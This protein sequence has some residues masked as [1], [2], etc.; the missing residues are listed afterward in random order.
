M[1]LLLVHH[2][3]NHL[4]SLLLLLLVTLC[5]VIKQGV[6]ITCYMCNSA[7][8][9]N[10]HS[11]TT[12]PE[13]NALFEQNCDH[14]PEALANRTNYTVCRKMNQKIF[15]N[16]GNTEDRI[17]RQCAT[18]TP[19]GCTWQTRPNTLHVEACHCETDLC[20]AA[21]GPGHSGTAWLGVVAPLLSCWLY[22][23]LALQTAGLF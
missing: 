12:M 5:A 13:E 19:V 23:R 6:A 22:G 4:S 1:H 14:L 18:E 15:D 21:T 20:N 9:R 16:N 3:P 8:T 7:P 17:I 2:P 10:D 11:C